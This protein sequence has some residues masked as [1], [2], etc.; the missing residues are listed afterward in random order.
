MNIL[1]GKLILY[2]KDTIIKQSM[3]VR[4]VAG[5]VPQNP[6]LYQDKREENAI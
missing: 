1:V 5:R 2:G 4:N 3:T 6:Q